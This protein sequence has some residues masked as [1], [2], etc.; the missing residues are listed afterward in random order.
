MKLPTP[1]L[2]AALL[3]FA[4]LAATAATAPAQNHD[5]ANTRDF[6]AFRIISDRNIFDPNRR[7][8]IV[9]GPAPKVV[10]SFSL[11]GTMDYQK[12]A[13]A[14]FDG[15]NQEYRRVL[16]KGGKID[17]YTVAVIQPNKVRLVSGTNELEL[18]V[19]TQ[20]QR[21]ESGEWAVRDG[22]S[23]ASYS[24]EGGRSQRSFRR[25]TGAYRPRGSSSTATATSP[26][27][28]AVET[29][30]PDAA[31]EAGP[32]PDGAPGDPNDPVARMM[33]RRQQENGETNPG[34]DNPNSN[35]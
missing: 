29:P 22:D 9:S 1:Y 10:D 6:S 31:I 20:V 25:S 4:C 28:G 12:G 11:V 17:G 24:S 18:N 21:S 8:R 7:P 33:R 32:P 2:S 34:T 30:P 13:F 23:Y 16:E 15:N 5:A 14:V 19:G 35:P 27:G 3:G 26:A